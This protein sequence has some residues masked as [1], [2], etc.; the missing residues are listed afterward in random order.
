MTSESPHVKQG[1]ESIP[2]RLEPV[3]APKYFDNIYVRMGKLVDKTPN[4]SGLHNLGLYG[5]EDIMPEP[6]GSGRFVNT[7]GTIKQL[8]FAISMVSV[9]EQLARDN[10]HES[11]HNIIKNC[12]EQRVLS[13]LR[14]I[15]L[16]SGNTPSFAIAAHVLGAKVYTADVINLDP[17]I[18]AKI[19][20]HIVVDLSQANALSVLKEATGSNFDLVTENINTLI[21]GSNVRVDVPYS[22]NIIMLAEGLLKVGG[23][24]YSDKV[25]GFQRQMGSPQMPLKRT[26]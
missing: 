2:A 5:F 10:Q 25:E 17:A 18:K 8:A 20:G 13:G 1:I 11:P 6:L 15:D 4:S 14:I 21:P 22:G 3:P 19:D 23:Y 24:L 12:R 26:R 16:G 9:A 7:F